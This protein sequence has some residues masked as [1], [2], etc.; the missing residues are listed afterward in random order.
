[1]PNKPQKTNRRHNNKNNKQIFHKKTKNKKQ[2]EAKRVIKRRYTKKFRNVKNKS[3]KSLQ[4]GGG[5]EVIGEGGFGCVHQPSLM[6]NEDV[7]SSYDGM[8]SKTLLK[9][10]ADKEL[11]EYEMIRRID[12]SNNYHLG[13]PIKCK[14]RNN[15]YNIT[16]LQ[17][18]TKSEVHSQP[19][20]KL[21]L[22]IMKNGGKSIFNYAREI[23]KIRPKS[24]GVHE[25]K[26]VLFSLA[27]ILE[28]LKTF[29][30]TQVIH[31]DLHTG[32]VLYDPK[33][34][35][36]YFIDFGFMLTMDDFLK[37]RTK[38]RWINPLES[39]FEN[40]FGFKTYLELSSTERQRFVSEVLGNSPVQKG[41]L[42]T[43]KIGEEMNK[44][45]KHIFDE[46]DKNWFKNEFS[47]FYT[48]YF[49]D[50]N[51]QL[52]EKK[53][54]SPLQTTENVS[55]SLHSDEYNQFVINA[56]YKLKRK[57]MYTFDI[58]SMSTIFLHLKRL[59]KYLGN[60][61]I[62]ETLREITKSMYHPDNSQRIQIEE[63]IIKYNIFLELVDPVRQQQQQDPI[64]TEALTEEEYTPILTEE[65][66]PILTEY[67]PILTEKHPQI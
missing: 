16:A 22:L 38:I 61:S 56:Y 45:M 48:I 37:L 27:K 18:C 53:H 36:S 44:F 21:S 4:K 20:E 46:E 10:D 11:E 1:M 9:N 33:S 59:A 30:K 15:T 26:N 67:T 24:D 51:K 58:Y 55:S 7:I 50:L 65:D 60:S 25:L 52:P 13:T 8:I 34:Q 14:P 29:Q 6:C 42:N 41:I 63:L 31:M 23:S 28:G 19:I 40:H 39:M 62:S 17:K 3:K 64:S 43:E 32:N 2:R 12:P 35:K 49:D 54:Y 47:K 57:N 66:P 5:A